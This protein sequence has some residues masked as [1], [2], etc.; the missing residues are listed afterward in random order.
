MYV[1]AINQADEGS[2]FDTRGFKQC[3]EQRSIGGSSPRFQ[4]PVDNLQ[5]AVSHEPCRRHGGWVAIDGTGSDAF[6][7][8]RHSTRVVEVDAR[9]WVVPSVACSAFPRYDPRS[10]R[11]QPSEIPPWDHCIPLQRAAFDNPSEHVCAGGY[12][13]DPVGGR[14]RHL[15]V[16]IECAAGERPLFKGQHAVL[17]ITGSRNREPREFRGTVRLGLTA[18]R[19]ICKKQ[20]TGQCAKGRND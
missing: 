18:C 7:M 17:A 12:A 19:R 16:K 13:L 14:N 8:H 1:V 20:R 4:P 9:M 2:P 11:E 6:R 5:E 15:S 3:R 10:L